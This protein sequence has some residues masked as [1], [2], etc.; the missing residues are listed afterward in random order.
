M[1]RILPM[2]ILLVHNHYQFAGGED[3]VVQA[4]KSMLE[5]H[6]H[7]VALLEADNAD[8]S[9]A[10]KQISTGF[11]AVHSRGAKKRVA[12]EL[13]RFRPSIMHV[14]NFFP[15]FSP[16]IYYAARQVGVAVVQTLHNYRLLCPNALFL[17]EGRPCEACLETAVP[18]PGVF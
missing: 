16:S 17:R 18:L 1:R 13:A 11:N 10:L 3:V 6:G 9:G 2:R 7:E 15:L 12:A 5:N 8:I 14:H 4:E